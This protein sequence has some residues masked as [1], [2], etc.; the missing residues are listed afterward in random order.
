MFQG[1]GAFD[2]RNDDTGGTPVAVAASRTATI[3]A[4]FSTKDWLIASTPCSDANFSH[5]RSR[6]VKALTPRSMPGRLRPLWERNSPPMM[7]RQRTS[8]PSI[9][10]VSSWIRPSFKNR[11]SPDLSAWGRRMKL[12]ET[13]PASPTISRVVRVKGAP[14]CNSM[15]SLSQ[16]ADPHL[17]AREVRHDGDSS[18]RRAGGGADVPD[19]LCMAVEITVREIEP[20]DIHPCIDQPFHDRHAIPTPVRWWRQFLFSGRQASRRA[21]FLTAGQPNHQDDHHQRCE[22]TLKKFLDWPAPFSLRFASVRRDGKHKSQPLDCRRKYRLY[23][24]GLPW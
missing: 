22:D 4:A 23:R 16:P 21:F 11:V 17:R 9:F 7:T 13:R 6:S 5:S 8:L 20:G 12:T 24:A 3:S 14:G 10:R 15:G 2:F 1:P 18:S 19:H